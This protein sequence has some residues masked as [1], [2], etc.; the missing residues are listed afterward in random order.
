MVDYAGISG[1]DTFASGPVSQLGIF[2]W[3]C[4]PIS[5][6]SITDGTSNTLLIGERPFMQITNNINDFWTYGYGWGFIL[7][8]P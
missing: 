6:S 7:L 1:Y 5:V 4:N 8:A 3:P 2:N